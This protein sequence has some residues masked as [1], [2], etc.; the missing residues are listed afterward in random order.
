MISQIFNEVKQ[1]NEDSIVSMQ[2]EGEETCCSCQTME[3]PKMTT[4]PDGLVTNIPD[5][6]LTDQYGMAGLLAYL[7]AINIDDSL[8]PIIIGYDLTDFGM[9]LDSKE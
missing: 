9:D 2:N 5:G 3:L 1:T 6:M 8:V 4:H 7:R